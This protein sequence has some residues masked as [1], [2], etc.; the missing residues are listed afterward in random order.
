MKTYEET[1][2]SVLEKRDELEKRNAQKKKRLKRTLIPLACCLAAV[3]AGVGLWRGGVLKGGQLTPPAETA[4]P[5]TEPAL[6]TDAATDPP[7]QSGEPA[8]TEAAV[9]QGTA[10]EVP[11]ATEPPAAAATAPAALPETT[12]AP[13]GGSYGG[14]GPVGGMTGYFCIPALPADREIVAV[15]EKITDE[16]AAAYFAGHRSSLVSSLS[17]SGVAADD[18]RISEKGYGHVCYAGLE[19]ER[20]EARENFRDYLVYNGDALVAIVTLYKE[21][22]QLYATPAFGAPWFA[23]YAAFLRAHRGE[24]IVYVYASGA[25][26][27]LTP[28]GGMYSALAGIVP[29]YYLQGVEDP[30]RLFYH[31]SAVF[32]P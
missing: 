5:G 1:V 29:E 7:M 18:I 28:D 31:P 23:E 20:L 25:E 12:D 27:I 30:Y 15:G 2:R 11:E 24:E 4:A 9:S 13:E 32:V 21:N 17:A 6:A 19:G 14:D 8:P 3:L 26:L 10:A 22:G 16:E